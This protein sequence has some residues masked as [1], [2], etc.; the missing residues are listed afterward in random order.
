MFSM[1]LPDPMLV[2][3]NAA[4]VRRRLISDWTI[5]SLLHISGV[6][7]D[8]HVAN[9]VPVCKNTS[10]VSPTFT[11]SRIDRT[12]DR[13]GFS[14]HPRR[15]VR[16]LALDVR[17]EAV[18][19]QRRYEL[20]YLLE[21]G[22]FGDIIRRVHGDD[23]ALTK[24][25][26]PFVPLDE[27]NVKTVYRGEEVGKS[28]IVNEDGDLPMLLGGQSIRPF[29]VVW[30]GRRINRPSI[31]KALDRYSRS[32]ILVQKSSSHLIAA[33]DQISADHSGYVFPQSVYAIE[34]GST[35]IDPLYLLCILNSAVMNEYIRRTVTGYKLLQPQLEL[36][37]V[38][39]LPVRRIEFTTPFSQRQLDV[40]HGVM[41]FEAESLRAGEGH[42]TN[43]FT[44][45]VYKNSRCP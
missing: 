25:Q 7:P 36:E 21:D 40:E 1:V 2:R 16:E 9:I 31:K 22:A 43:L 6:F 15:M 33:F 44:K 23:A 42:D 26:P 19:A 28:A 45:L 13:R 14:L 37:D 30:E 10:P 34:V 41:L 12:A 3:E 4:E 18:L 38:R 5:Q 17:R 8:A 39:S 32:K 11:A 35:G 24:Y 29:E 20:L 27:L